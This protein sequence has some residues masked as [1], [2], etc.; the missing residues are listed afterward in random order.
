ML[1]SNSPTSNFLFVLVERLE[2][3]RGSSFSFVII[4]EFPK[5]PMWEYTLLPYDQ[6]KYSLSSIEN[7]TF[8]YYY[9]IP[10]VIDWN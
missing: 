6:N 2:D 1:L 5:S 3:K 7:I 9:G 4:R 8:E 10:V